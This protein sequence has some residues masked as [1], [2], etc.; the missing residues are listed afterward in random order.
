LHEMS[1]QVSLGRQS[2]LQIHTITWTQFFEVRAS[3]CLFEKIEGKTIAAPRSRCEA[4]TIHGNA[5]AG[6]RSFPDSRRCNLQLRLLFACCSRII[7][8]DLCNQAGEHD[9]PLFKSELPMKRASLT[10]ERLAG[11]AGCHLRVARS[12]F[13]SL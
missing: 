7:L 2:A 13:A 3:D 5:I 6:P 8:A 11:Y 10:S 1:A 9:D 12:K 4:A